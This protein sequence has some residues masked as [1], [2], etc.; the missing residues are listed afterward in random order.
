LE[1]NKLLT[2]RNLCLHFEG[3]SK[4]KFHVVV[5]GCVFDIQKYEKRAF[6]LQLEVV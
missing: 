2:V 6:S 3:W 5:V 1:I 4:F